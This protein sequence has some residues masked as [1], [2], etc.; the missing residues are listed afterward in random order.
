MGAT[1]A[2]EGQVPGP[3][4]SLIRPRGPGAC[5]CP[6]T[7]SGVSP[8]K[9]SVGAIDLPT[10]RVGRSIAS[11]PGRVPPRRW[12]T[13]PGIPIY[14]VGSPIGIQYTYGILYTYRVPYRVW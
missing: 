6:Q 8:Q 10:L 1:G 13:L 2:P 9:R 4:G 12:G 7:S 5:P 14:P 11:I 3:R